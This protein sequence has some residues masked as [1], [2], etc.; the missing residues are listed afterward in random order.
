MA[1]SMSK[2]L[3][4]YYRKYQSKNKHCSRLT[5]S[6]KAIGGKCTVSKTMRSQSKY[7]VLFVFH[8]HDLTRT[9]FQE[10]TGSCHVNVPSPK[11]VSSQSAINRWSDCIGPDRD[12]CHLGT[13]STTLQH[14][15]HN[16]SSLWNP[17]TQCCSAMPLC[18]AECILHAKL[19]SLDF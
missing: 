2:P 8:S 13:L 10:W 4:H 19:T 12:S 5:Q 7:Q 3:S 14:F 16:A 9:C 11:A 15:T 1:M 18:A 6:G 17:V